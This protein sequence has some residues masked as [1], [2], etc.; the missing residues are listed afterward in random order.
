MWVSE[1]QRNAVLFYCFSA[2]DT[3]GYDGLLRYR[4]IRRAVG[5]D[6]DGPFLRSKI[7]KSRTRHP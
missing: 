2:A 5:R 7:P 1:V 3:L 6:R 4:Y